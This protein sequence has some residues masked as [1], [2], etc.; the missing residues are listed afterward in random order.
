[1]SHEGTG[2]ENGLLE[3]R[4]Q[5]NQL[6]LNDDAFELHPSSTSPKGMHYTGE[7]YVADSDADKIFGY[8]VRPNSRTPRT[9]VLQDGNNDPT[10][11]WASG[12]IMWVADE[13]D[14]KL[15]AYDMYPTRD[16]MPERDVNGI[17]GNPAGIWSDYDQ[18]YIL[19]S[20][21]YE[22]SGYKMPRR[23]YSPHVVSGLTYVEYP[24]NSTH[25]V[26]HYI[27]QDPENRSVSWSLYPSGDD[28]HFDIYDGY[29]RFSSPPN[30]EDP[31]DSNGDNIYQLVLR[32]SSGEFAH[33]YFPVKVKVT[34]VL[35]EQ[36]MFTD[37]STT[38]T[39]D[40]NTLAGENIG[41]PVE[42]VNPDDDPIHIY[43][44]SGT[45]AASFDFSTSIGQ[46]ITRAALDYE[47]KDSYSVRVSIRD[48]ENEDQ[49]PSTST[50]DSINVT[51]EVT[52]VDEGPEVSGPSQ[53][54]YDE[55][56]TEDVAEFTATNPGERHTC[57]VPR[58]RRCSRLHH[59]QHH[60]RRN[61]SIR[62]DT[63]LRG[64]G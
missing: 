45:D 8:A 19:D 47:T 49:S 6:V 58:R 2:P 37:T 32:A 11:I 50:D 17:T 41:D 27:A 36:P 30:F 24:E 40:E 3:Y 44:M 46:I 51:I 63:G 62:H 57:L 26:G 33:T 23:N 60:R 14:D 28:Q 31:K 64:P 1:M 13:E 34:D 42:A 10:G 59:R 53:V 43:S 52:N 7:I 54:D 15:Y 29:L 5:S 9:Y 16:H 20:D 22:I 61:P 48:G 12:H 35:G 56:D 21:A 18:I 55:N 25:N 39:V 38:R 4:K